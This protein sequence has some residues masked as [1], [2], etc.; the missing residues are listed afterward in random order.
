MPWLFL[1]FAALAGLAMAIQG[2]MNSVLTKNTGIWPAMLWVHVTGT[3]IVVLIVLI[4]KA[5]VA[6]LWTVKCP[7]PVYLGG[8]L[9]VIII[10]GVIKSIPEIGVANATTAIVFAQLLVAMGIDYLGL[11]GLEKLPFAWWHLAGVALIT[12]GARLMLICGH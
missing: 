9:N 5:P 12:V 7:W 10:W 3:C 1:G 11:W 6:E 4:T 2:T 8:I